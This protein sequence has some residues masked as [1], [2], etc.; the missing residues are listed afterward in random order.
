MNTR[1]LVISAETFPVSEIRNK[2]SFKAGSLIGIAVANHQ[3]IEYL[4]FSYDSILALKYRGGVWKRFEHARGDLKTA[5]VH[6]SIVNEAL[7]G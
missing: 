4:I 3:E 5:R 1:D 2:Q 7:H 6:I